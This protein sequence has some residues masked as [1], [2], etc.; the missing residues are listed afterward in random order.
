MAAKGLAW[1]DLIAFPR[2]GSL[3]NAA[4]EHSCTAFECR[5][6]GIVVSPNKGMDAIALAGLDKF[7][8]TTTIV[9][10]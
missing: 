2:H 8:T 7:S 10:A 3:A 4:N 5:S 1:W 6:Y 9:L